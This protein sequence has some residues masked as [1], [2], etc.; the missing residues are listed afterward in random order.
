MCRQ[1]PYGSLYMGRG[2]ISVSLL[3]HCLQRLSSIHLVRSLSL[4]PPSLLFLGSRYLMEIGDLTYCLAVPLLFWDCPDSFCDRFC[5]HRGGK[6]SYFTYLHLHQATSRIITIYYLEVRVKLGTLNKRFL[7]DNPSIYLLFK[8]KGMFF[9][10]AR[11]PIFP[12]A[13]LAPPFPWLSLCLF[14]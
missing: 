13:L 9:F 3:P 12:Y 11:P 8:K 5:L 14:H 1:A 6:G 4:F 2:W 7:G 10:A